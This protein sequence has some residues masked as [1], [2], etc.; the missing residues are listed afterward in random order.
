MLAGE[1]SLMPM[2]KAR[3]VSAWVVR[4]STVTPTAIRREITALTARP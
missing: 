3:R 2:S 4:D 1:Y